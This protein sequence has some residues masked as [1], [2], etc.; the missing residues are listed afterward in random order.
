MRDE[1]REIVAE[2]RERKR[3]MDGDEERERERK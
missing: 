1:R 2:G 3:N